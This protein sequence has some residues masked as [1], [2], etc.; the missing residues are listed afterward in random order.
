MALGTVIKRH[1]CMYGFDTYLSVQSGICN[2]C[3]LQLYGTD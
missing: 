1:E 2:A 3:L